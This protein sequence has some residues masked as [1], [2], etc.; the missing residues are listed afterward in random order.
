MFE[1][2]EIVDAIKENAGELAAELYHDVAQPAAQPVG[3]LVGLVPRAVKAALFPLEKWILGREYNL[4]ETQKLLEQKLANVAP[5]SIHSPEPYIAVPALQNISY[6][7]DNEELRDMYANLLANSMTEVVKDG[8]H[9][10]FVDIIKQLCP[11]EAKILRYMSKYT[12]IPTITLQYVNKD[13]SGIT[14]GFIDV[15]KSFSNIGENIGCEKPLNINTYFNN[16]E[17]LGLI[18]DYN[19]GRELI[20]KNLY[21]PLKQHAYIIEHSN[22]PLVQSRGFTK[23]RIKEGVVELTYYGEAFCEVCISK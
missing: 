5:E 2:N 23:T 1:D 21:E 12:T 17:R 6:C 20:D 11:D 18:K 13:E 3:Q 9:P 22:E 16:L 10:G 19:D 14:I 8:V 4:L 15:I 7:M